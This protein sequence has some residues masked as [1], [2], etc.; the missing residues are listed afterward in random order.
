M[1][2]F[3]GCNK[4]VDDV[5]EGYTNTT[6]RDNEAGRAVYDGSEVVM[7]VNGEDVTWDEFFDMTCY[8]IADYE[9][10]YGPIKDFSA[11]TGTGTM[12]DVIKDD[13]SYYINLFAAAEENA[14]K[15]NISYPDDIDDQIAETWAND[16]EQHGTEEDLIAFVNDYYGSRANYEYIL[17]TNILHNLIFT[18]LY[19]EGAEDITDQQIE[20]NADD[21]I[22]AKQILVETVDENGDPLDDISKIAKMARAQEVLTKLNSYTGDDLEG[23]FD[24]LMEEY[25]D[26]DGSQYYP[27]GYL[28]TDGDMVEEFYEAAKALKVGEISGIVESSYGYHIIL[29][30]P[31]NRDSIPINY[32]RYG[33]SYT[34]KY[35]VAN[36]LFT[37]VFNGWVEENDV[38]YTPFYDGID[39][40]KVFPAEE[41]DE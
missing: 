1:G 41:T 11:G 23:Y 34:L 30:L 9:G 12:S 10:T 27:A 21:Y 32:A 13:A 31:L 14:E 4:K 39:L 29:R 35:I 36:R 26:D 38:T 17:K 20:E 33:V 19:G 18:E 8:A 16:I 24:Q 6:G 2:V 3:T 28:F 15:M 5:I 40:S 22:Q 25:N 37:E 7:T